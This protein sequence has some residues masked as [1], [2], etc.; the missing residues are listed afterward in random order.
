MAEKFLPLLGA[1]VVGGIVS[2]AATSAARS[3]AGC[4]GGKGPDPGGLYEYSVVYT[5]RA[6][7]HMSKKF[8]ATFKEIT[9][10]LRS[11][12]NGKTAIII[13]GS[14]TYAME[15]VARQF[16]T[17]KRCL[18]I[19]NGYF[20]FRWSDIFNGCKI[21]KEET[22]LNAEPLQDEK[23]ITREFQPCPLEQVL[24]QVRQSKPDVVFAPHVE[25]SSGI[26]LPED[27]IKQVAAAVHEYGGLFVLDCIAS[28]CIWVD[29]VKTGVDVI[30]SAPQKGWSGP[31]CAGYVM[32]SEKAS[33]QLVD[34]SATVQGGG[35]S[36]NLWKWY[37]IA[38]AYE[39]GGHAYYSTMPTD[40]LVKAC[41][42]MRENAAFGFDKLCE[43]Q[44]KLG[45]DIRALLTEKGYTSVAAKGY[46]AP[47]VV[48]VYSPRAS[49]AQ[50]FAA[51]GIQIAGGVP[52]MV[53]K[54]TDSQNPG[55]QTF[56]LGLFGLDKLGN[57]P[58]TVKRLRDVLDK[59]P[60][61]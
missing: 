39:N 18:V 27:Y 52:L 22:V 30:I 2:Y 14:G 13:P 35:F 50:E 45:K 20:S 53:G 26:F 21:P 3:R 19:R 38:Q 60:S 4:T 46:E 29:M 48:V 11:T 24:A 37:G 57:I 56:R 61:P 42:A 32:L 33:K 5:D 7:N 25:T 59:L 43:A 54:G 17:G 28:G 34:E 10:T 23:C 12:Y 47:G 58:R 31:A 44:W 9:A 8:Q 40:A 41:E 49:I 15:A 1:A 55:F 16:G 36:T 6:L 51:N